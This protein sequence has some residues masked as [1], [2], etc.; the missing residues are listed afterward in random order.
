MSY[1]LVELKAKC[2]SCRKVFVVT[3]AQMTEARDIGC[4]FCA[5]GS[6]ATVERATARQ[7]KSRGRKS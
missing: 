3:E 2:T 4:L 7:T 5:C 1:E 6:V